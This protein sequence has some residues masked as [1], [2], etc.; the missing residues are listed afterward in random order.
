MKEK[1]E[2]VGVLV[3]VNGE[4]KTVESNGCYFKGW[5]WSNDDMSDSGVDLEV[6]IDDKYYKLSL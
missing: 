6:T 3:K 5:E 2:F 4:L 1:I